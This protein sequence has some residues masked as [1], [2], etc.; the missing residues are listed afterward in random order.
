MQIFIYFHHT[1]HF[2]F[3]FIHKK[4]RDIV[5]NKSEILCNQHII[6]SIFQNTI[7]Q[8]YV[9]IQCL[10]TVLPL[11]NIHYSIKINT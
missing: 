10:G 9:P 1:K 5:K 2:S 7:I 6:K 11:P 4:K 8:P 3:E